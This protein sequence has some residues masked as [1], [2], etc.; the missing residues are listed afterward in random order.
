MSKKIYVLDSVKPVE[1]F[2]ESCLTTTKRVSGTHRAFYCLC[3]A[4][5]VKYIR[6]SVEYGLIEVSLYY[7]FTLNFL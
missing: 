6:F 4:D 5:L 3:F 2:V 1:V 7:I